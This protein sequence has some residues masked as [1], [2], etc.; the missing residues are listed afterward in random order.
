M[1]KFYIKTGELSEYSFSCGYIQRE[2]KNGIQLDLYHDGCYHVRA[3]DFDNHDRL[4]WDG[5]PTLTEARKSFRK[6]RTALNNNKLFKRPN[7]T[8]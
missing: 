6:D 1:L 3:Y 7:N 2:E 5:F 4:F 8:D